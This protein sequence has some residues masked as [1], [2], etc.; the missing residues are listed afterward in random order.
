M[1]DLLL[2]NKVGVSNITFCKHEFRCLELGFF[3]PFYE[4]LPS[5]EQV[6]GA[7]CISRLVVY[8]ARMIF[9]YGL[10]YGL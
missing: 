6:L 9:F 1:R 2:L 3:Q 5:L 10:A 4:K 7:R 8:E